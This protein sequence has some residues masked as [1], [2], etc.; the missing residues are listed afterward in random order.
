MANPSVSSS[1]KM[2]STL[3]L[4]DVVCIIV[5]VIVGSGI[6]QTPPMIAGWVGTPV[7]ILFVWFLGGFL[8]LVGALCYA[9]LATTYPREGGDYWYLNRAYGGW[10][11]FL[12][13]WAKLLVIRTGSI[14]SI[15][16]IL[17]N[18]A[19]ELYAFPHSTLIYALSAVILLTLVNCLG[20]REGKYT[21]DILTVAKIIGLIGIFIVAIFVRS[22]NPQ[23]MQ[24]FELTAGGF[25][26]ALIFVQFTYGGWNECAYVAAEVRNP[27]KNILR[28]LVLGTVLV[29]VI[30]LL[31]NAAFIYALG[32]EKLA[33]S[34]AVAA[35]V[36]SL[37]LGPLGAR[38]VSALV[39][40]S[41]LGAVNGYILT[42]ARIS[43]A[44]GSEHKI[45]SFMGYWNERHG[46][47]IVALIT[48]G[49]IVSILVC[50]GRFEVLIKYTTPAH[51]FFFLMTGVSLFI[52]RYKD[53]DIERP[54]R[55]FLYPITPII[56]ILSC[57]MLFYSGLNYAGTTALIGFVIVL[58]GLPV[59]YFSNWLAKKS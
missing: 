16:Y 49:V 48:Q 36:F 18:Y 9:E 39:V 24:D 21:Q 28:S 3:S 20:I 13:A 45:F 56:F 57:A 7:M 29:T 6:F 50:S 30:Y 44:L 12:F 38:L 26:L 47:P 25:F 4:F 19:T 46:T 17:A 37:W 2:K 15:S 8:S 23:P 11:G 52:L 58:A 42:G 31:L 54:Y 33:N 43:Y 5:G 59:Y 1:P 55:V 35:D 34:E 40:I 10:A 41:T 14:A 51:W 53:K 27:K 22:P 32:V